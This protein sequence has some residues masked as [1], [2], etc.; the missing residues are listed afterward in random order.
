MSQLL[1]QIKSYEKI[2]EEN[3]PVIT[4]SKEIVECLRKVIF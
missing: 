4:G 3:F 1:L 2:I